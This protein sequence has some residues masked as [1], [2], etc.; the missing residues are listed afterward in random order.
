MN[1]ETARRIASTVLN[2]ELATTTV[3][4]YRRDAARLL[5]DIEQA[6]GGLGEAAETLVRLATDKDWSD[7]T[8][9]KYKAALQ[10]ALA[11]RLMNAVREVDQARQSQDRKAPHKA[12]REMNATAAGLV[13]LC[14]DPGHERRDDP[15]VQRAY[16][17][18][19]KPRRRS[20]RR[21]VQELQEHGLAPLLSEL[22]AT[23]RPGVLVLA[24]TGARPEE[25]RK[26][27]DLEVVGAQLVATIEGAK[28]SE[29]S[30]QSWRRLHL[31]T[32]DPAVGLAAKIAQKL[33]DDRGVLTV[34]HP[35]DERWRSAFRRAAKRAGMPHVSPYTLRHWFSAEA[36]SCGVGRSELAAAMGHL[37]DRTQQ[38]Y[39]QTRQGRGNSALRSASADRPVK[40]RPGWLEY[41]P[42][43][44]PSG[45][46]RPG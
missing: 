10:H 27:I 13:G 30:G 22:P 17:S 18:S 12:R 1:Q 5:P 44:D 2:H 6:A 21:S 4:Q 33:A 28:V 31:D 43:P 15:R 42:E 7:K 25:L 11:H 3:K 8:F 39:G 37:V 24:V 23:D 46:L 40:H 16:R 20:K 26:G 35:C 41:R 36:K 19:K 29:H 45:G 14:P 9:Y 32:A 38:N 34:R